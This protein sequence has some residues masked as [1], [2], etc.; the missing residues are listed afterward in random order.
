[1]LTV[2]TVPI[3]LYCAKLRIV[4]R[5]K[6][7]EW[8]ERPPTGGYGSDE[9]KRIVVSGNLPAL[10]DGSLLVAD[11][12]AIAEYLEEKHPSPS[13]LPTEPG[14]RAKARELSRFHDTRLEPELRKLFKNLSMKDRDT[15]LNE[16]QAAE[17]NKRLLQLSEM[18]DHSAK[19]LLLAH[20]G[21]P[22]SF[23][24]IEALIPLLSLE[25]NWP[26]KVSTWRKKIET[27]PA[28]TEELADYR[29][30]LRNWLDTV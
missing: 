19:H 8:E 12:E 7:V 15:R 21:Y 11:S 28:V 24:W 14:L 6:Q 16:L 22:I 2:Y 25:V 10:E 1:M 4:L 27:F 30:K 29:P 18:I 5:H 17:I 13:M 26:K 20:C 23:A 3:S 9:Y